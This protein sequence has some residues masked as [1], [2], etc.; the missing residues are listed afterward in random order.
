MMLSTSQYLLLIAIKLE[1]GYRVRS[2]D[3]MTKS[4]L[5]TD[6]GDSL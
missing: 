6:V 3:S 1:R 4:I 2:E 5:V